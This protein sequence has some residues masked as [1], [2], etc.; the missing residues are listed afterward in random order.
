MRGKMVP[1]AL[2]ELSD[3]MAVL[4]VVPEGTEQGWGQ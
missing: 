1:G 4:L 3:K 2:G